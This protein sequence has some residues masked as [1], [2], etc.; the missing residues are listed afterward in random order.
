[1]DRL[2][3]WDENPKSEWEYIEHG[4]CE[5]ALVLRTGLAER[6]RGDRLRGLLFKDAIECEREAGPCIRTTLGGMD[7][8][9]DMCGISGVGGTLSCKGISN[10]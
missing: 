4:A 10:R 5:G 1:M 2:V 8:I 9:G 6:C 7:V 3:E